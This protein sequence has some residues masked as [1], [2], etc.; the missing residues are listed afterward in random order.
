MRFCLPKKKYE[1]LEIAEP[2]HNRFNSNGLRFF[3]SNHRISGFSHFFK[4]FGFFKKP[5][6]IKHRSLVQPVGSAGPVRFLKPW[7]IWT[8]CFPCFFPY[9]PLNCLSYFQHQYLLYFFGLQRILIWLSC[10][11]LF[12]DK[13]PPPPPP[14]SLSLSPKHIFFLFL[15]FFNPFPTRP[16]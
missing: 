14:L 13:N 1:I 10:S 4:I 15:L 9:C 8:L 12:S 6:R 16:F 5:D 7:L 2:A 11:S 3:Q